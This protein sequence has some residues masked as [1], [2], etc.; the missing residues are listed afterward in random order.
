MI[1]EEVLLDGKD[2]YNNGAP[3]NLEDCYYQYRIG[4]YKDGE[5]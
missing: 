3:S 4:S 5:I 2:I 1:R